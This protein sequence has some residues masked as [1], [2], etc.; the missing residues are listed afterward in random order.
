MT[1]QL[2]LSDD[3]V[4]VTGGGRGIGEEIVYAFAEAGADVVVAA[5]SEDEVSRVAERARTEFDVGAVA[6]PTDLADRDEIAAL[7]DATVDEFG[8]PSVLVNNAGANIAGPPLDMTADEVDTMFDVN[9]RGLFLLSQEFGRAVRESSLE[10]GRILNISSVVADLGVPAMTVYA[11][12]KSA[13][14][15]LTKGMAAE[16]APDGVTVNSIS[17]G[18]V[19]IDRTEQVMEEHGDELFDFDRIPLGRVGEPRDVAN[20]C[21]FF[22]S[23]LADYV[24]GEDLLVDG[25]VEF[26][27]GLYK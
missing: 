22:A 9:V 27:A 17:P 24:T 16:L 1:I 23:D 21:L 10:S 14:R 4:I 20:A 6:V 7:V 13:V 25:G 12:T 15:G 5:R 3:T 2:D 11:G 18:L 26:T 19:R 8:T